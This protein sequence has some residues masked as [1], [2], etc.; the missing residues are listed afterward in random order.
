MDD[1][2][3]SRRFAEGQ[4]RTLQRHVKRWRA[5]QAPAKD[6]LFPRSTTPAVCPP[7]TSPPAVTST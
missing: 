7:V 3:I 4:L 1:D 2:Y 5:L 6:V